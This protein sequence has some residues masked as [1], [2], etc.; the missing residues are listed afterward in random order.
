MEIEEKE[1]SQEEDDW[2]AVVDEL[3][4]ELDSGSGDSEMESGSGDSESGDSESGS[5]S[6]DSDET[7][8]PTKK[9][10]R[11]MKVTNDEEFVGLVS[12]VSKTKARSKDSDADSDEDQVFI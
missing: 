8:E 6:G 2:A 12:P 11:N 9:Q 1:P 4:K 7:D 5:G 10:C 3:F